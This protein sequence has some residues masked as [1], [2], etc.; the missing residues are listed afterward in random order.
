MNLQSMLAAFVAT[1][2]S[3][4]EGDVN[5]AF[6]S[7]RN[8]HKDHISVAIDDREWAVVASM[9]GCL[10]KN[11]ILVHDALIAHDRGRQH[12]VEDH[13]ER[14]MGDMRHLLEK[15]EENGWV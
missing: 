2:L 9:R 14:V 4:E 12:V 11:M 1:L 13:V 15:L 3:L 5:A 10:A 8:A 7:M 6:S